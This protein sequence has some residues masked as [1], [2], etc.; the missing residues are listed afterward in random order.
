MNS[1]ATG[2]D[3]PDVIAQHIG[4]DLRMVWESALNA[5]ALAFARKR[6]DQIVDRTKHADETILGD[7]A[8][9]LLL[10]GFDP[11]R[12]FV[13]AVL[14]RRGLKDLEAQMRS[15]D[16]SAETISAVVDSLSSASYALAESKTLESLRAIE[17]P[18]LARKGPICS[19]SPCVVSMQSG[20]HFLVTIDGTIQTS[21]PL[22]MSGPVSDLILSASPS[23]RQ[24]THTSEA[25]VVGNLHR[26][27][28]YFHWLA[29][30][31]PSIITLAQA[32]IS[33]I[34]LPSEISAIASTSLEMVAA[35]YGTDF[36]ALDGIIRLDRAHFVDPGRLARPRAVTR[37]F[38]VGND[39]PRASRRLY[40]SRASA[41]RRRV[42]NEDELL[43]VL[44]SADVEVVA[45]ETLTLKEQIAIFNDACLTIGPHGA[46]LTNAMFMPPGS[47]V[48]EISSPRVPRTI[49]ESFTSEFGISHEYLA[50]ESGLDGSET[51]ATDIYL[52]PDKLRL[53]LSQEC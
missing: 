53:A 38:L 11:E 28:N 17:R 40:V 36:I 1:I 32:E 23:E 3:L 20:R 24:G 22:P 43:P 51:Q 29:Q 15:R 48:I 49:F 2:T 10:S 12:T 6:I 45:C 4:D 47:H 41:R 16:V 34:F 46:G 9:H 25:G 31:L 44:R 5:G 42:I 30:Y 39:R 19:V 35:R 14:L 27:T 21:L 18:L 52:D 33:T 37:S 13:S 50:G 26:A 7:F 8:V